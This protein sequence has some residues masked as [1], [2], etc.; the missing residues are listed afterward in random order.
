[1]NQADD[2]RLARIGDLPLFTGIW[3]VVV[4]V[5]LATAVCI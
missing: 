4:L 1:M 3:S 5:V 2:D